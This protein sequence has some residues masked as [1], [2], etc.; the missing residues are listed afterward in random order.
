MTRKYHTDV[1]E[2]VF[3]AAERKGLTQADLADLA[4][5][6][7]KHISLWRS[8]K[9]QIS[10]PMAETLMRELGIMLMVPPSRTQP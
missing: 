1:R 10:L 7:P 9:G 2:A 8:G 3:A 4:G 6:S 5:C